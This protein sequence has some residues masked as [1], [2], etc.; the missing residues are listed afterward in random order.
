MSGV[1]RRT[2]VRVELA[3]DSRWRGEPY[4][5]TQSPLLERQLAMGGAV[6]DPR[7]RI[8]ATLRGCRPR[9]LHFGAAA[10]EY[11]AAQT[12]AAVFDVGDRRHLEFTGRDRRPFLHGFRY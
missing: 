12:H 1:R 5:V 2:D 8:P 7:H 11:Q 4:A 10:R 3:P 9:L 6:A